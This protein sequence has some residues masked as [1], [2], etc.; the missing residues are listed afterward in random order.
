MIVLKACSLRVRQWSAWLQTS[1]K[2]VGWPRPSWPTGHQLATVGIK[3]DKGTVST[4]PVGIHPIPRYLQVFRSA[5]F[6]PTQTWIAHGLNLMLGLAILGDLW[7]GEKR[8]FKKPKRLFAQP[9]GRR[10]GPQESQRIYLLKY[11]KI[12]EVLRLQSHL[13]PRMHRLHSEQILYYHV[14]TTVPPILLSFQILFFHFPHFS[15]YFA[16]LLLRKASHFVLW[17]LRWLG[18][19]QHGLRCILCEPHSLGDMVG[20]MGNIGHGS[21]TSVANCWR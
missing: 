15:P 17:R 5:R 12:S 14:F 9:V 21:K 11:L 6:A 4:Q 13:S 10:T 2:V 3:D 20:Q 7:E 18:T 8:D 16:L 1:P 19:R